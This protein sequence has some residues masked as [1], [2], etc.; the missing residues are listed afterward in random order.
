MLTPA[1]KITLGH[2]LID[3]TDKPKASTIT[4]LTVQLDFDTPADSFTLVMGNVGG[5]KPKRE[6]KTKIELGYA[7]NGDLTQVMTGKVVTVE[8]NLTTTR[9]VGYSAGAAVLR[10][11]TEQTYESKTAG[12]IVRDLAEKASMEVATA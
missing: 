7:D 10:T 2:K 11:T 6:D 3:T 1:Y 4:D 8:P 12:A 5:F 9:V